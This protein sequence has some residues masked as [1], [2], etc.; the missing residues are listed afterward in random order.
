[1]KRLTIHRN[2]QDASVNQ[3]KTIYFGLKR[4]KVKNDPLSKT[5]KNVM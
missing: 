2:S 5:I 1:M 4:K 3:K